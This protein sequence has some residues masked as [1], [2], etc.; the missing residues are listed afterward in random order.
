MI[1]Q[2]LIKVMAGAVALG[3]L[4]FAA[5]AVTQA[6]NITSVKVTIGAVTWCDISQACTHQIWNLGPGGIDLTGGK[7]LVMT[8]AQLSQAS[9]NYNFDTSE[10][11]TFTPVITINGV[12]FTDTTK[13]LNNLGTDPET[14]S[15]QE[16]FDWT[17]LGSNGGISLWVGYAD[18][19]HGGTTGLGSQQCSDANHT[20]LPE[21]PWLTSAT[22]TFLGAPVAGGCAPPGT[23]TVNPDLACFDAGA[24]RIELAPVQT[25]EPSV[26][27]SLGTGLIAIAM[28]FR[29]SLKNRA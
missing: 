21:N 4:M 10:E 25:P 23:T 27:L 9:G 16:A 29:K 26:L 12:V 11:Q 2:K 15:H 3:A 8:Q 13:V 6:A 1:K 22:N 20:C 5:P 7:S 17:S 18:T 19:A 24:L 28:M 14:T